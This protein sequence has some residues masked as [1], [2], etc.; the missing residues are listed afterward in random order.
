MN[1]I[2]KLLV[3][4]LVLTSNVLA[5]V[6][7]AELVQP[8]AFF[9]GQSAGTMFTT[10]DGITFAAYGEAV[11]RW[12]DAL[13]KPN[14]ATQSTAGFHPIRST[15]PIT[16]V[17]NLINYSQDI[18][19]WSKIGA[20]VNSNVETNPN[21]NIP[22]DRV[23]PGISS[24]RVE[25]DTP[26][27]IGKSYMV[28]V[29]MKKGSQLEGTTLV[30]ITGA[31]GSPTINNFYPTLT[32]NWQ[33]FFFPIGS[34]HG[35]TTI[36]L[37]IYPSVT[38]FTVG[39][40]I[41]IG[42]VQFE[43]ASSP[44]PYQRRVTQHEVY[45][46]GVPNR[47][48]LWLDGSDDFMAADALGALF[49]G[50]DKPYTIIA[51]AR[52]RALSGF[53][54]LAMIASSS[55]TNPYVYLHASNADNRYQI[56]NRGDIGSASSSF[57]NFGTPLVLT[58]Q[59]LTATYDSSGTKTYK[60]GTFIDSTTQLRGATTVDWFTLGAFRRSGTPTGSNFWS[61]DYYALLVFDKALTEQERQAVEGWAA[62]YY[63]IGNWDSRLRNWSLP[64]FGGNDSDAHYRTWH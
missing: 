49:S 63:Q 35:Q 55:S 38:G 7:P 25:I 6:Y 56:Q 51:I 41:I 20:T 47:D 43:Q 30:A 33:Q 26:V 31:G 58:P 42:G 4:L 21:G 44:T 14:P 39:D 16:G 5:Q 17:R 57:T 27:E 2:K 9:D 15:A 64:N 34:A 19:S 50:T 24:N 8:A 45:E 29:W 11:G 52:P 3:S 61:G 36:R 40:N 54:T 1:T 53:H 23:T 18:N 59:I 22:G 12:S 62:R 48:Y 46:T 60:D 28:A 13:G 37:R 32:D 10:H